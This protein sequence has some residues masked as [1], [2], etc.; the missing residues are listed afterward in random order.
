MEVQWIE[1]KT[2]IYETNEYYK[3]EIY[4]FSALAFNEELPCKS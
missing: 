4:L 2:Q 1:W 3:S